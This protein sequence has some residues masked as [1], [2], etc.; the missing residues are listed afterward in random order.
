MLSS[1]IKNLY[2][3]LIERAQGNRASEWFTQDMFANVLEVDPQKYGLSGNMEDQSILIRSSVAIDTM[4]TAMV[5]EKN[6]E[7]THTAKIFGEDLL[8]GVLPMGSNGLG[9]VFPQFM[10]AAELRAGSVTN[11]NISSLFGH[12]TINYEKLLKNGLVKT[13]EDCNNHLLDLSLSTMQKDFYKGVKI[14]CEAV[15]K[16]AQSFADIAENY[17][18]KLDINSTRHQELLKMAEIARK[19]PKYPAET[20]HEALQ[21]IAF[22]HIALHSSMNFIS[23]GRLDQVLNEYLEKENDKERALEIFE[24]FIIKLAGRLN[25]NMN[26]ISEQDHVDYATVLGTHPYFIDQRAGI[27]NFLQN[28]IIG[29]KTPKGDDATNS[30][31]YLILE[32]FKNVNLSTPGIYIRIHQNTPHELLT[33]VGDAL[34]V[35]KNNPAILNDE[36]MIPALYNSLLQDI[37]QDDLDAIQNAQELANDYCVDGCWEPILNGKCDWT[38]SMF[39]AM[40]ALEVALNSGASISPDSELFRGAKIAPA[41]KTPRSFTELMQIF[42][43]QVG[44]F[45]DQA[46]LSMFL[47]YMIDEYASPSLLLSAML[48][49]CIQKGRDKS[50]GGVDYNL[51][52]VVFGGIPNVVNTLAAIKKWVFP[53]S[54][55]GKYKVDDVISAFRSNFIAG[56]VTNRKLQDKF[57]SIQVDFDTNTGKFANNDGEVDE[58]TREVLDICYN[59]VQNSAA[60]AKELYQKKPEAENLDKIVSLRSLTGYYGESFEEKF[61]KFNVKIT[62]GAGTFEQYNWQGR[63]IAASADRNLGD[64]LAPNFSPVPGTSSN[65]VVGILESF[66][67][68]GIDRFGAGIITDI[69]LDEA[70]SS[71]D[72]IFK[73]LKLAI[74]KKSPM[75]TLSVGSSS[76][77]KEIYEKVKIANAL[78]NSDDAA[79]LLAPYANINVRIG[80][81]QTPFI[82]LPLSHMENYINRPIDFAGSV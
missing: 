27:N 19:V 54:G 34:S 58:I 72:I 24:C 22:Y 33:A 3:D 69:C 70:H 25:L 10:T 78:T 5:D 18:N 20:F 32:A 62:V 59:T 52:G 45:V 17:A 50:W 12:N 79:K 57:S 63:S 30:M 73:I 44:F 53:E 76:I 51:A 37:P 41:T 13:I 9:K 49:G 7:F 35:T 1:R 67:K 61:Q 11:R 68:L 4:L 81:W 40:S 47:Y 43:D 64:P 66:S 8:L 48:D 39:N 56:D 38:F 46:V 16:Y 2:N 71:S 42:K 36:T 82:T 31:T 6:S 55:V 28:I 65:G 23:L 29:G 21:S 80:G 75:L 26:N 14:S 15:I 77:Y 60:F 74:D